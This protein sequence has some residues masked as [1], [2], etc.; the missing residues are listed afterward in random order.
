MTRHT[1]EERLVYQDCG[2]SPGVLVQVQKVRNIG[3][4]QKNQE[5]DAGVETDSDEDGGQETTQAKIE[6]FEN[7]YLE[8]KEVAG[9]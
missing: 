2:E 8:A 5:E 9:G 7:K 1:F 3:M 6:R 4:A